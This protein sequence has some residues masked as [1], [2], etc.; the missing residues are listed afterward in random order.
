MNVPDIEDFEDPNQAVWHV[1]NNTDWS[2]WWLVIVESFHALVFCLMIMSHR[3]AWHV[4]SA[5]IFVSLLALMYFAQFL[6]TLGAQHHLKFT[7]EQYFDANGLFITLILSFPCAI[8][9]IFF[10][11]SWLVQSWSLMVDIRV[12]QSRQMAQKEE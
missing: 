2:E 10:I 4:L 1:L 3:A 6:N 7:T 8:N 9:C 12:K 11:M 5:V